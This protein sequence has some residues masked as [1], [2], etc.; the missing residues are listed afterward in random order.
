M[1]NRPLPLAC[2][3][4]CEGET[5]THAEKTLFSAAQPFGFILFARNCKTPDQVRALCNEIRATVGWHCPILIDQEGGRIARLK[6]PQWQ[7]FP[8]AKSFGDKIACGQGCDDLMRAMT[9]LA[10]MQKDLGIDVDCAPVCDVLFPETHDIIGDRAYSDR[11]DIVAEAAIA[12]SRAFI[13]A[14]VTPIIKHL[15]GHGRAV[16]DSHLELPVVTTSRAEL[17]QTDFAAFRDVMKATDIAPKL[18]GMIA[19]IIYTDI[20]KDLPITLSKKGI[21]DIIRGFIGFDGLLLSDDLEMKAL[22]NFGTISERANL[23]LQAGCDI[24][25][26]CWP[27]LDIMEKLAADCPPLSAKGWERWQKSAL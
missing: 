9:E 5:L 6:A 4:A 2:I 10:K 20:D 19:H 22:E 21:D 1:Q 3:F 11:A 17:E 23:S 14:G 13:A 27:K 24:A 15:P 25:L 8:T 26:Y 12:T 16:S 7:E 18:W